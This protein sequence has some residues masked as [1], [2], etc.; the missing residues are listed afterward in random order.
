MFKATFQVYGSPEVRE[1][2][3]KD[4]VERDCW[5]AEFKDCCSMIKIVEVFH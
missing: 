3:F 1:K 5:M 4:K 2:F